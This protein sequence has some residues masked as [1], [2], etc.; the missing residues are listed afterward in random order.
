M[1]FDLPII[2]TK[3]NNGVNFL[4]PEKYGITCKPKSSVDLKDA[5][6]KLTLENKTYQMILKFHLIYNLFDLSIER[7]CEMGSKDIGIFLF[8][9]FQAFYYIA[10]HPPSTI[11]MEPV[12]YEAASEDKKAATEAISSLLANL[13]KGTIFL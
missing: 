6:L 11:I 8:L 2:N 10:V 9:F 3:L 5:I 4:V 13:F 12:I 1:C 7:Y